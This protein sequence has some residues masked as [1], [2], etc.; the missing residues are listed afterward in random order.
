MTETEVNEQIRK[1]VLESLAWREGIMNFADGD[2]LL[3]NG[4]ITSLGIYRLV[5]FFEENFHIRVPDDDL[6]PDNFRTIT[7]MGRYVR[8][9]MTVTGRPTAA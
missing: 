8:E 9:R 4:V 7:D 1:F 6:V 2:S 3:E 5:M